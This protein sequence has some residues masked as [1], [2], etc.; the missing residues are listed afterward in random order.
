MSTWLGKSGRHNRDSTS[1]VASGFEGGG[2]PSGIDSNLKDGTT[3][4]EVAPRDLTSSF[5]EQKSDQIAPTT[6]VLYT[7]VGRHPPPSTGRS[8]F[9]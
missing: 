6:T 2:R 1:C 7:A 3:F 4:K 5:R 9:L 8:S